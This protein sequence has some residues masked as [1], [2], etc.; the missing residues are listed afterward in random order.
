MTTPFA[1]RLAEAV[2]LKDSCLL[3]GLDPVLERLPA[4]VLHGGSPSDPREAAARALTAFNAEVIRAVAPY[5]CAVKPQLAFYEEWGPPG[6]RAFEAT[7]Q[8]ARDAGLLVI[9]DAK[10]GDIDSTAA[11]YARTFLA[12]QSGSPRCD[13]VTVNPYLGSDSVRPFIDAAQATGGG[14]FVLVRT[15]NPSAVELQDLDVAGSPLY[16]HVADLV[17][18]W[19]RALVGSSGYSSLGAV[20]GAT[21]PAQLGRVRD[22][23]PGTWLL[24]PGVGAQ[25]ASASDVAPAFDAQGLGAVVNASRAVIYAFRSPA[26]RDWAAEV[27]AAAR[28]LRDD[29]RR[30]AHRVTSA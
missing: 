5:A 6:I 12:S 9:A 29:L 10:R 28:G 21:A 27:S 11:A 23:L 25:G 4:A 2:R 16:L 7:V 19:G 17:R 3:V 26:A 22:A 8:L 14:L 1:D 13:A 24:V 20:V 15:S 18:T 30:A